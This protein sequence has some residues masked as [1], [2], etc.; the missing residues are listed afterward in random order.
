M[1]FGLRVCVCV[2]V[3]E[4]AIQAQTKEDFDLKDALEAQQ[5]N[6]TDREALS[7][8]LEGSRPEGATLRD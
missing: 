4:D 1:R 8:L 2:F 3:S 6:K 5:K 7:A